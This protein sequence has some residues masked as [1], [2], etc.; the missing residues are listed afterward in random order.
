MRDA[1]NSV[2]YC[3]SV[4]TEWCEEYEGIQGYIKGLDSWVESTFT[5]CKS[6]KNTK[7]NQAMWRL[8]VSL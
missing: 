3:M 5:F 4:K 2:R 1:P 8:Q 7:P 6:Q